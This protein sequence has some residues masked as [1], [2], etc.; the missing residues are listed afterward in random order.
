MR[1][2][3]L[4]IVMLVLSGCS[5]VFYEDGSG[6]IVLADGLG[7]TGEGWCGSVWGAFDSPDDRLEVGCFTP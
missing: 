2:L 5:S 1:L 3:L 6:L 7:P 4:M